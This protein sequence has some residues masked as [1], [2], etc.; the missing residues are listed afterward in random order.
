MERLNLISLC[1]RPAV[2]AFNGWL[3]LRWRA[4][5]QAGGR[6]CEALLKCRQESELELAKLV[7]SYEKL[8][9]R[10]D[11]AAAHTKGEAAA[12]SAAA[13]VNRAQ[14]ESSARQEVPLR[15][16]HEKDNKRINYAPRARGANVHS[17]PETHTHR[18]YTHSE[19]SDGQLSCFPRL[20]QT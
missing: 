19:Q 20:A 18:T 1:G 15:R 5:G 14:S 13:A 4:A 2:T 12:A 6:G 16:T 9:A 11:C 3:Q 17:N 7:D 10:K 8:P